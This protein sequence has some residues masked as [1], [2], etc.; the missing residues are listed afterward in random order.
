MLRQQPRAP[1]MLSVSKKVRQEMLDLQKIL[2]PAI[3]KVNATVESSLKRRKTIPMKNRTLKSPTPIEFKS[4][5]VVT[6]QS[7]QQT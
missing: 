6:P 1:R 5:E 2:K 3:D 4:P 7:S